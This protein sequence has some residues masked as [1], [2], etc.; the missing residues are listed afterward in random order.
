MTA[1]VA[2]FGI[3]NR[4]R[5]DDALG[6]M[7]LD[8]LGDWLRSRVTGQGFELFEAYQLQVENAL[9]LEGREL[10]L[11]IDACRGAPRAAQLRKLE[12]A[13]TTPSFHSHMLE[14]QAVL[15][16]QR[17]VTGRAPPPAF[18]LGVRAESFELG[19]G[20]SGPAQEAF[21]EAWRLLEALAGSPR[22]DSW[23]ALASPTR[24]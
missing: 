23:E 17:R 19:E 7:L 9:D 10:V 22:L 3:G 20:L 21:G 1:P 4:S 13:V 2:V 16:V 24:D 8:R 6:P 11:F 14:P 18:A 12:P 5:G 15:G